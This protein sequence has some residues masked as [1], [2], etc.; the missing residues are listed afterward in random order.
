MSFAKKIATSTLFAAAVLTNTLPALSDQQRTKDELGQIIREYLLENPEIMI[1][2]QQALEEKQRLEIAENQAQTIENNKQ[3]IFDSP[4][5]INF[6]NPEAEKVIVEFFDYNCGFCQRALADMQQFLA[7]DDSVRFVLKEFPVLGPQSMEAS[8]ASIAFGQLAPEK[9]PEY[10]IA[11]LSLEG[12]KD[13]ERAIEL[14]E[15]MGVPRKALLEEMD[16]QSTTEAVQEVYTIADGLS[17]SGTP[18][19]IVESEVVFGAVGYNEL[20]TVM[21]SQ[22]Q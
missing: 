2:V 19:Y 9:H 13:G 18:S 1:E 4:Y 5:Q 11:L 7:D 17:I 3:A 20:K 12:I 14:A 22:K 8:R 16:K 6:G 21:E 15:S 10:H